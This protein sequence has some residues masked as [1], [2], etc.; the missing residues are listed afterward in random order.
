MLP[1]FV[2]NSLR[3]GRPSAAGQV[4]RAS[5]AH[6]YKIA[7]VSGKSS[8]SPYADALVTFNLIHHGF[9]GDD[10]RNYPLVYTVR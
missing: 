1:T 7:L 10:H 5:K 8:P 9:C 4:R 3:A 2:V 6:S